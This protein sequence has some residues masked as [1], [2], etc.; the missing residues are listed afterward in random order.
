MAELVSIKR[1]VDVSPGQAAPAVFHC[2]QGDVGSKIILG[3]L[4]NGT[5]YSIPS[6]V[7]VTIEGS[8][9]NG[10]IFTPISATASGSDITFYLTGEMTAVAGPAI[11]QAVLKSGS[12]IL[13]TANFTLEV[14]S[15]PMGADAPPVFTDAGW[16]W[17]LN[18]L[19]TEFV[20]AL[21]DNIIDAIDSKADQS[22]LTALSNTVAGHTGSITV[23]NS[24]VNTLNQGV[25]EN[26][27]DIATKLDKNQGTANAGKYLKVGADGN[28]ETADLDVTTDKTLSIADKA[29]DAKAVGDE[30]NS[31]KAD[32]NGCYKKSV[33]TETD[34]TSVTIDNFDGATN[35]VSL[36][37]S[38]APT[39]TGTGNPSFSNVRPINGMSAQSVNV[40]DT[41]VEILLT[42]GNGNSYTVY[43]GT[44]DLVKGIAHI[45]GVTDVFTGESVYDYS[46]GTVPYVTCSMSRLCNAAGYNIAKSDK[47]SKLGVNKDGSY[48]LPSYSTPRVRLF[49][50]LFTSKATA[51]SILNENPVQF[52]YGLTTPFDMQLSTNEL[53]LEVGV[54]EISIDEKSFTIS[55]STGL[56]G[57]VKNVV[58]DMDIQANSDP[59]GL[60]S[61]ALLYAERV[62]EY[63]IK[64]T[65]N[66]T[67]FTEAQGYLDNKISQIPKNGKSFIYITDTHWDGNQKHS[68]DLINYIRKRT[69]IRKV[70]FGGD[71]FGNAANCYLAMQKAGSYLNQVKRAFGYD[72]IP[73]VGDHDHNTVN[74]PDGSEYFLPYEQ[75][76]ELFVSELERRPEYHFYDASEKLA[77][78]AAVGSDDYNGAM[79]FFHTVYYVDDKLSQIR[80][81]SLNTGCGGSYGS[82][83][84]IFGTSGSTLLR[85]QAD[86]LA[87]TLMT[88][89]NGYDI[90]I[91]SHKG[92]TSYAGTAATV[93]NSIIVAFKTKTSAN[94]RPATDGGSNVDV[95]WPNT[96]RYD[97]SDAPD[98]G[99]VIT[100]NGHH[101]ADRLAWFGYKN[102]TNYNN[103]TQTIASGGAII[104]PDMYDTTIK[105]SQI[106]IIVTACDSLGA[107]ESTS[108]SMTAGTITEQCFDIVTIVDDGIVITRIGAGEDR[109]LY[110]SKTYT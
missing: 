87:E 8:E 41:S 26:R 18:K 38:V 52:F 74:M 21:G 53:N 46:S 34:I 91:L 9:S 7:T 3:L 72:Y 51:I 56:Y 86:W 25:T 79:A 66:P 32:L 98:V 61:D 11:C 12:N 13:G 14:E 103:N 96:T 60:S 83:Y 31:L 94:P 33:V 10:S 109:K 68:T 24:T 78:F 73:T 43:S 104:Q 16:T 67:S 108:P 44:V 59:Y 45:T 54:N 50:T 106:P 76:E 62:P 23:L 105:T 4:N 97:F 5:A 102:G 37:I 63:Y 29:A 71:V 22:D 47:F 95:W 88:T 20:P 36:I 107:A 85:L 100:I 19:T 82:M 69:G 35:I 48:Y 70:L 17:M 30:I 90:V 65:T 93:I 55:Y 57:T 99:Y 42:D 64:S 84:N 92:N 75:I 77:N 40:N 1:N 28:V 39:Q 49:S 27:Q 101:H 58:D 81:I 89:P 2:S 15:S 80:F 6:G 110:I